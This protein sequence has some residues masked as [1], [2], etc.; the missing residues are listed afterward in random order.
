MCL[1]TTI[2]SWPQLF[3][4]GR[5]YLFLF[6]ENVKN[7]R[8]KYFLNHPNSQ[9]LSSYLIIQLQ[10][11]ELFLLVLNLIQSVPLKCLWY[12]KTKFLVLLNADKMPGR[13]LKKQFLVSTINMFSDE[14]M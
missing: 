8:L 3:V 2:C 9:Y 13:S 4:L 12:V 1:A 7:S 14:K 6:A 11:R 10:V 5:N